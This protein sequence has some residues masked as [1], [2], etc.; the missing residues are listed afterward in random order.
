MTGLPFVWAFWAGRDGVARTP[1]TSRSLLQARDAGVTAIGADRGA[2]FPRLRPS[3]SAW[4]PDTCGIISS[5][6]LGADERAG[7]ELFYRYAAEAGVVDRR[8]RC[9]S[10]RGLGLRLKA[11]G[12]KPEPKP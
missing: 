11:H 3:A 1:T 6:A 9:D 2:V 7:L 5:T 12:R 4:R 8:D 10:F